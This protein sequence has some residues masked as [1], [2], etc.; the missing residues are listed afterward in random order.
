VKSWKI[1]VKAAGLQDGSEYRNSSIMSKIDTHS[2]ITTSSP[3]STNNKNLAV[4][5]K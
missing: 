3:Y 4:T 5:A 2:T 1:S